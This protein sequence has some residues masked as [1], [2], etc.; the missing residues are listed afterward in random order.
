MPHTDPADRD[1]V[2]PA[3]GGAPHPTGLRV[4]TLGPV[5]AWLGDRELDLGPPLRRAVFV[6]L[7]MAM[8]RPVSVHEL[9]EALWADAAPATAEGSVHTYLSG[10]RNSLEPDPKRRRNSTW[11]TSTG[12]AYQLCLHA[13]ALDADCLRRHHANAR[14]LTLRGDLSSAVAEL[15]CAL[16]LWSGTPFSGVPGPF[17]EA[18]RTRLTELML[19]IAE[20]LAQALL[21]L[22]RT[23]ATLV[24]ELTTLTKDYPFRE[25][26]H[27]LLMRV[28]CRLGRQADALAIFHNLSE[29]LATEL[30]TLPVAELQRLYERILAN[31]PELGATGDGTE[32]TAPTPQPAVHPPAQLPHDINGF[33]GRTGELA[34][35]RS[36][37]ADPRRAGERLLPRDNVVLIEGTAG[38]GKT[39]LA[40][41]IAH[42]LADRF[43]DGQLYLDLRGFDPHDPPVSAK[44]ALEHLLRGLGQDRQSIPID[45]AELRQRYHHRLTGQRLLI[46]LDNAAAAEQIEQ[47]V[48]ESPTCLFL[49]TSRNNI[50]ERLA[51]RHT[52]RIGLDVLDPTEA[53]TLLTGLI[54]ADRVADDQYA[55]RSITRLCGR[56]PLAL[57]LAAAHVIGNP[58][59][60]LPDLL[61]QFTEQARL[62][63]LATEDDGAAT[64]RS[65]FSWS[66]HALRPATATMFRLLG[67]HPTTSFSA[68]AATALTGLPDAAARTCLLEL[69]GGHLVEVIGED[70]YRCHDLLHVYAA[71]LATEHDSDTDRARAHGRLL[72]FYIDRTDGAGTM[73]NPL[74]TRVDLGGRHT[75][76]EVRE[77]TDYAAARQWSETELG[78]LAAAVRRAFELGDHTRTW[79]L[80]AVMFDVLYAGRHWAEWTSTYQLG[81]TAA[82]RLGDLRA[83][84][85]LRT[86]LGF[87]YIDLR[88]FEAA[89]EC[90]RTAY[91]WSIAESDPQT[92]ATCLQGLGMVYTY[93]GRFAEALATSHE[94]LE[95]FQERHD[96]WSIA[97][98]LN[99]IGV[100]HKI[101][102]EFAEASHYLGRALRL[103]ESYDHPAC[104]G[105]SLIN[106][107]AV[108]LQLGR[109]EDARLLLVRAVE[110]CSRA[111]MPLSE[112]QALLH[113]GKVVE[114]TSGPSAAREY[115]QRSW[116]IFQD[117]G[118][119]GSSLAMEC[120]KL[121]DEA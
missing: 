8:G 38:V 60:G 69:V 81:I 101:T 37:L 97:W 53:I 18:E 23:H 43:P 113:L 49:V 58:M 106:L 39:A 44:D 35:V 15:D 20:D 118:D 32:Q 26:L 90:W 120:R 12:T 42:Q 16:R 47:L 48:T 3:P 27:G 59:L 2:T 100:V 94:A 36:M 11:L 1:P 103:C 21:D 66:Y 30:G 52:R 121:L 13:E 68:A 95:I 17:A 108:N 77:F 50:G 31:D 83:A 112:A 93:T 41:H 80:T 88:R 99:N 67:L 75:R 4:N 96:Q 85:R 62:D 28:L 73:L 54:G 91:Q 115:W 98:L 76:Y 10:L 64:A 46:L 84:S 51:Y 104:K 71:E 63:V 25:R 114:Q 109:Y 70:R 56:L 57:R 107:G 110:H 116:A 34:M 119:V 9:I 86:G 7:A 24:A 92:Q 6:V 14:K 61:E 111:G 117:L 33:T 78:N 72:D 89:T 102:G 82:E 65:V 19:T 74:R 29:D 22:G 79:Q 5:R 40:V 105:F 45:T 55:A 87:A